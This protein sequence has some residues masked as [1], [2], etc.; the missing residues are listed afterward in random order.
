MGNKAQGSEK[1][2]TFQ[3]F[4]H[5]SSGQGY[6][7]QTISNLY[8]KVLRE[9]YVELVEEADIC[10]CLF[11]KS[12]FLHYICYVLAPKTSNDTQELSYLLNLR[13]QMTFRK[14][15]SKIKRNVTF[16]EHFIRLHSPIPLSFLHLQDAC[17]E[18]FY[19]SPHR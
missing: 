6:T 3:L 9:E 14:S 4:P 5:F 10:P 7:R 15:N 18:A 17:F 8:L 19:L 16:R 11:V 2:E 13:N 1:E 12:A